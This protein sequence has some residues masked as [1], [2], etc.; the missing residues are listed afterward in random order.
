MTGPA[1]AIGVTGDAVF[2]NPETGGVKV[3]AGS[4]IWGPLAA[5]TQP[6][7]NYMVVVPQDWTQATCNALFQG[8]V[9]PATAAGARGTATRFGCMFNDEPLVVW[10]DFTARSC[11]W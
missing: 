7:E 8:F 10:D 4:V 6:P 11:G 5:N 3:C 2:A 1:G 9:G